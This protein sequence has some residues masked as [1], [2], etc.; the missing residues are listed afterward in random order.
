MNG[1]GGNVNTSGPGYSTPKQW[2]EPSIDSRGP[3]R[4][5]TARSKK[6]SHTAV[7][8]AG[9]DLWD[10]NDDEVDKCDTGSP[11]QTPPPSEHAPAYASGDASQG[12]QLQFCS[13]SRSRCPIVFPVLASRVGSTSNNSFE[14]HVAAFFGYLGCRLP[15]AWSFGRSPVPFA[16]WA[17]ALINA[18]PG[19]EE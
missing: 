2:D 5:D 8:N 7:D 11:S 17:S 18:L 13:R 16:L 9:Q 19:V 14:Q 15:D 6:P 12:E 1:R 4:S 3:F 10:K